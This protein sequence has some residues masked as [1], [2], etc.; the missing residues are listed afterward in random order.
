MI[1]REDSKSEKESEGHKMKNRE[2]GME[3]SGEWENKSVSRNHCVKENILKV[4]H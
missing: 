3:E 4:Y 1:K 2:K